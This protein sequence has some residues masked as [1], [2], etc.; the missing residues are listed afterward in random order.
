MWNKLNSSW[1]PRID[2]SP[3]EIIK[4]SGTF[5]LERCAD[6]RRL[7]VGF[8]SLR[9]RF[10]GGR[11]KP[12]PFVMQAMQLFQN[13]NIISSPSR[14][15]RLRVWVAPLVS[16]EVGCTVKTSGSRSHWEGAQGGQEE[17]GCYR[18]SSAPHAANQLAGVSSA[19]AGVVLEPERSRILCVKPARQTRQRCHDGHSS[20]RKVRRMISFSKRIPCVL[21]NRMA[22][23]NYYSI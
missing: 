14:R 8:S 7:C 13:T 19:S 15:G 3:T 23:V 6:V 18:S 17:F 10:L 5:A 1:F 11:N 22:A 16:A 20:V 9:G 4:W 21:H 12:F 2:W